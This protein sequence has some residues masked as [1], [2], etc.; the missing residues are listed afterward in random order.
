M[1]FGWR[2]LVPATRASILVAVCVVSYANGLAGDFTYDDKAIV[3]DNARLRTPGRVPTLFTTPYF[4]GPRGQGTGYRP[5]LLLS[6][7]VQWWLHRGAPVGFHVVNVA[8]HALVTL[9]LLR[10]LSRLEV[11]EPVSFGAAL[12]FAVHPVH[13]EAVT[14]LVGRGET[15]AAAF[16][17]GVVLFA[18]RYRDRE[19]SR[20]K[21]L[22]LA[23]LCFALGVFSKESAAVAPLLVLLAYWRLEPGGI[24][25]RF[26]RALSRGFPVYAGCAVLLA[27]NLL[28]RRAVLGGAIKAPTF[29]IFEL[30]N[31]LAHVSTVERISNSAAILFRYVGRLLV[32]L[33][34]SADESAWSIPVRRG[35]D[36]VGAAAIALWVALLA[37]AVFREREKREVA[38]GVLF[39]AA[40]FASTANVFFAIGTILAERVAYLPSAGFALALASIV[41]GRPPASDRPRGRVFLLLAIGLAYAART[42]ARNPVW[43]DDEALFA[44]TVNTSPASAKAHYN[45]AW[46]SAKRGRLPIAL[47][48]YTRATR[49]YPK[50]FDA[51]AGKGGVEQRLGRLADAERSFRQSLVARPSYENGFFRLGEVLEVQGNLAGAERTFAAGLAKNPKSTPLAFRLAKIRARLGRPSADADWRNAIALAHGSSAF[52]LGYAEWLVGQGRMPEARHEAREVLRRRPRDTAALAI[53]SDS[54]EKTEHLFAAGLAAEKIFRVTRSPDDLDRLVC[55]AAADPVYRVRFAALEP[56]LRRLVSSRRSGPP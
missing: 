3:L 25:E 10:L 6:Y 44:A 16:V 56:A 12:I 52:R 38:F 27:G 55:I 26:G 33:R 46:I 32:P 41:L 49:I 15:L 19:K 9:L 40:A 51:W 2:K 8:L 1:K 18:V 43:K 20:W 22:A 17:F 31:P 14:S 47:E 39:F 36:P 37:A 48:E 42:V 21:D 34:L 50:Y 24:L 28:A 35:F 23:L 53:L 4:G 30:E 29:V 11:P 13:V 7:A 54:S 45:F 5:V